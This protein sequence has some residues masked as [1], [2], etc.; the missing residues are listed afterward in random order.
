MTELE[1]RTTIEDALRSYC[2]GID[3]LHAPSIVAAFHPGAALV[4][5]GPQPLRIEEFVEH[6]LASLGSKFVATQHRLSNVT[7]EVTGDRA[8]VESYMLAYHVEATG[9]E[10]RLHTFSGRYID[11]FEERHGAWKIA[12]RTLRNDWSM[13]V[14]MGESMSGSWVASGRAGSPDPIFD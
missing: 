10:R 13:V 7:V 1:I 2:R 4:D 11:R 5:Y 3:R 14:P 12:Q 9:G 8:L 6:A